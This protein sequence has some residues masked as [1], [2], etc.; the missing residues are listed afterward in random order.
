M[1]S[2]QDSIAVIYCIVLYAHP[3][4]ISRDCKTAGTCDTLNTILILA[5]D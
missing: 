4:N 2:N 5:T 3:Y 1:F